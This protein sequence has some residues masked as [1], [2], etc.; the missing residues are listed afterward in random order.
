MRINIMSEYDDKVQQQRDKL[1]AEK[2]AKGVRSLQ[3][4]SL[5]SMWYDDR[6]Q[7]TDNGSV[8]DVHYND[9]SIQ[10]TIQSTGETVIM[11]EQLTGEDLVYEYSRHNSK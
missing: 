11:G 6:P 1:A 5:K 4:H 10:R 2:W 3:A 7:D 9:G 8:M